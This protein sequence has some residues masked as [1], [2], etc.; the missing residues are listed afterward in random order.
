MGQTCLMS[1]FELEAEEAKRALGQRVMDEKIAALKP[2]DGRPKPCPCCGKSS[3]RRA[4]GVE[5]TFRSMSGE[6][7]FRRDY[8]YC[9][10]CSKGFYPR[11]AFL[12]LPEHGAETIELERRPADFAIDDTNDAASERWNFHYP[13]RTSANQ[14]RQVIKRL[15]AKLDAALTNPARMHAAYPLHE[16]G[17]ALE[18]VLSLRREH[19][20]CG[21]CSAELDRLVQQPSAAR[22]LRLRAASRI[23]RDVVSKSVV[24]HGGLTRTNESPQYRGD[25]ALA[26][27]LLSY[28][29]IE[30]TRRRQSSR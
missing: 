28:R 9:E 8:C 21:I 16:P 15:G 24:G 10:R 29:M 2:E 13:L 27:R 30:L 17:V 3:K 5:R 4:T 11:D 19:R 12:G 14:F 25:S 26:R 20:C 18:T 23:R 22:A 1:Q 6:H 7:T